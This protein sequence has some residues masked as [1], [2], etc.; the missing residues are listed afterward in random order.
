MDNKDLEEIK[1]ALSKFKDLKSLEQK[2]EDEGLQITALDLNSIASI[3]L[4]DYMASTNLPTLGSSYLYNSTIGTMGSGNSGQLGGGNGSNVYISASPTTA[5]LWNSTPYQIQ[6]P[7]STLHVEGDAEFK[8]DIKWKGRSLGDML[9]TI[10]R[11]L[12]ILKPDPEKLEHFEALRKAYE[13]Y[14]TLE[15]LCDLPKKED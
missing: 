7:P 6:P 3:N 15:A 11:R 8:G 1:I 12:A 4:D 9:E 14:K 2:N 13:H 5:G 10:E